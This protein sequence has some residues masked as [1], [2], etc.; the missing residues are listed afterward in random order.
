MIYT[1]VLS[2]KPIHPTI[3][4]LVLGN[5]HIGMEYRIYFTRSGNKELKRVPIRICSAF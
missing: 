4:D 1:F 2:G 5:K 3:I